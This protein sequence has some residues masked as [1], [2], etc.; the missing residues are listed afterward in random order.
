MRLFGLIGYPLGHSFS[1]TYFRDKFR[2]ENINDCEYR[3]FPIRS[4]KEILDILEEN[5]WLEG[6]NVTIPY[7]KQI[8]PFIDDLYSPAK[9][10]GAVNTIKIE[11]TPGSPVQVLKGYNTD[12]HGFITSLQEVLHDDVDKALI[13]GSGGAAAAVNYALTD[14]GISSQIVSRKFSGNNLSYE[15]LDEKIMKEHLLLVNTTPLGTY[16]EINEAPDIPYNHIGSSHILFDLVYNP[17]ETLFMKRGKER[18]AS[19][20]NGYDMLV[21]QAEKSW[22]IWNT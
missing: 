3:N 16:P 17:S 10:I 9:E 19:V 20:K 8:I 11:S 5:P 12:I 21:G 1:E 18:G 15:D 6:L 2:K 4:V 7:K 22:D 13:L 14:M